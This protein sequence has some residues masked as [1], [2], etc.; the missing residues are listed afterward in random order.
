MKSYPYQ[1]TTSGIFG[2]VQRP[3]ITIKIYSSIKDVW[4]PIHNILADT[5]ADI[6]LLPRYIGEIIIEDITNGREIK[7]RGVVPYSELV[8][9]IHNIKIEVAG[10]EIETPVAISDSDITPIILGRV[11]G[12]DLFNVSFVNGEQIIFEE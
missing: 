4:V 3:L 5:G 12:L 8:A 9:Y 1:K 6:T 7:L 10:K 11:K 2:I